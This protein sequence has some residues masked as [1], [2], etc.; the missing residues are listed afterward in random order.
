M[1]NIRV[2]SN[3]P[4]FGKISIPAKAFI[5][6]PAIRTILENEHGI[7]GKHLRA[8]DS[9]ALRISLISEVAPE[10]GIEESV[11]LCVLPPK[12][13]K[14]ERRLLTEVGR[15][16]NQIFASM[17][18]KAC[19][20]EEAYRMSLRSFGSHRINARSSV[21]VSK[22]ERGLKGETARFAK[23]Y[24]TGDLRSI[25][26]LRNSISIQS[27]REEKIR[28]VAGVQ[29]RQADSLLAKVVTERWNQIV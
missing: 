27:E 9:S 18:K 14:I 3:K 8:L 7:T 12:D 28:K 6:T 22:I 29:G 20:M 16:S 15:H 17:V 24:N 5:N 25:R 21:E 19:A 26:D 1:N 2:N 10:L 4:A 13:S 11:G 23:A